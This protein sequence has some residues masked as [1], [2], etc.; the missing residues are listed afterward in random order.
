MLTIVLRTKSTKDIKGMV[1]K[2]KGRE[3]K[4]FDIFGVGDYILSRLYHARN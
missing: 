2:E 4:D 3:L 1:Y